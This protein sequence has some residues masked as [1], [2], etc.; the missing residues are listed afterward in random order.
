MK[1]QVLVSTMNIIK[2][3]D[4]KKLINDM[5][6]TNKSSL[7]INQCPNIDD[8][9]IYDY[10]FDLSKL[11]SCKEKGLSR[12][13]NCAIEKSV[14]DICIIADDDIVYE[15]NYEEVILEAYRKN[16]RADVIIFYVENVKDRDA[17]KTGLI[18]FFHALRVCS[19]QI[20]FRKDKIISKNIKFDTLFGTGSGCFS[21]GEENIF[22]TDCIKKGL[23]VYYVPD[24][25]ATLTNFASSWFNGYDQL[26]WESVGAELYRM[27]IILHFPLM[28]MFLIRKRKLY[29]NSYKWQEVLKFM[30]SGIKKYKKIK[31][32]E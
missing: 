11:Y 27:S 8:N 18:D 32:G 28:I 14:G 5:N 19:V 7:V 25:I 30:F 12:S 31:R 10:E 9:Q 4:Y 13:R 6:L 16:P 1:A 22:L 17:F 23:K 20:T 24:K 21:H 15:T 29:K 26:F 3:K 2:E